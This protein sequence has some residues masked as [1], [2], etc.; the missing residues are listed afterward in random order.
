MRSI[1]SGKL[2][3]RGPVNSY[4]CREWPGCVRVATAASATSSVS[5]NGSGVNPTGS[6]TTP[7]RIGSSRND[8]L[9]F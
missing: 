1:A 8:S 5:T 4:S 7:V 9:K 3:A 6:A 2:I